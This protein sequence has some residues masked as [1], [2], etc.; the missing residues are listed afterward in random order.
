[1]TKSC[2]SLLENKESS[3]SENQFCSESRDKD[4]ECLDIS[5]FGLGKIGLTLVSCLAA[6][7]HRVVGVDVSSDLVEGL[8]DHTIRSNEP[9]VESR[10]RSSFDR[11]LATSNVLEAINKTS[12]SFIIVPT[13]SNSLG[14]FSLRFVLGACNAIGQAIRA[15]DGYHVVSLVSTVLPGSSD[16]FIIPQLEEASGRKMGKG[17]GFC[18]NPSFIAQ[19]EVVKGIETPDFIL[20]GE[21]DKAAG[22][23]VL[24]AHRLLIPETTPIARMCPIEAEITKLASNTHETMR[25]SFAN[26]LLAACS[27]VPCANVDR[28][29]SALS[30]RMGKRFF[31][32]AVPYGGPCWPRDNKAL[33]AFLEAIDVPSRMP[34]NVDIFNEEHGCYI[35][36]KV[37]E[38]SQPE[39][40][41]GILGLAYKTGTYLI[42]R[43]FAID[44]I[45]WL[46]AERRSICAWDPMAMSEVSQLMGDKVTLTVNGNHC[47]QEASIIVIATPLKELETIDWSLAKNKTVIDCWRCLTENQIEQVGH[48]VPLGQGKELDQDTFFSIHFKNK[49]NLL[50]N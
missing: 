42:E 10:L 38:Q 30:H 36:R 4:R 23:L 19:G 44:L 2:E 22:D 40:K 47:L 28:V 9:G 1:M 50:T 25:V 8:S 37:L 14:G 31:K 24:A 6:A 12:I 16:Q 46:L 15:K 27:E 3:L 32:G 29:T 33:S 13:P 20:I 39:D 48:Y 18:Y 35:L 17:L 45:H 7:G 21:T 26:M 11:I 49:L 41:I 34:R 43:S 5:V